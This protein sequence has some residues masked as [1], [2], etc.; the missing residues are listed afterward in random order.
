MENRNENNILLNNNKT[1]IISW[2][3]E[4]HTDIVKALQKHGC[5]YIKGRDE[6]SLLKEVVLPKLT[7]DL[8]I[9]KNDNNEN[10]ENIRVKKRSF[11]K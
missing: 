7:E 11:S 2:T 1:S 6:Y 10:P 9:G 8:Y 4:Q 3:F 5:E